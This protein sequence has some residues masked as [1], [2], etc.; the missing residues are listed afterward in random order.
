M[1]CRKYLRMSES[2]LSRKLHIHS[3]LVL[4]C[5]LGVPRVPSTFQPANGPLLMSPREIASYLE[6][7]MHRTAVR[8]R[9][10]DSRCS[11]A[12]ASASVHVRL[13][14][15]VRP[16]GLAR[17]CLRIN[18]RIHTNSCTGILRVNV[19]LGACT[20]IR[21]GANCKKKLVISARRNS[22]PKKPLDILFPLKNI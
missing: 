14:I 6:R 10:F 1:A 2:F 18:N 16:V 9:V 12:D 17:C 5:T 3:W 11:D 13:I 7:E 19:V 15:T 20:R 22:S 4:L 21:I 8:N